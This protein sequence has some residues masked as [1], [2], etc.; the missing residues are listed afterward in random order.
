MFQLTPHYPRRIKAPNLNS[1]SS[2]LPFGM[3][4]E[5]KLE[6]VINNSDFPFP[7][8]VVQPRSVIFLDALVN[9]SFML[10]SNEIFE[11]E[12]TDLFLETLPGRIIAVETVVGDEVRHLQSFQESSSAKFLIQNI[13]DFSK[14][15]QIRELVIPK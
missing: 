5:R 13:G 15:A 6:C 1:K 4:S 9:R 7:D 14:R 12:I 11:G 8:C 3:V 10:S 2:F